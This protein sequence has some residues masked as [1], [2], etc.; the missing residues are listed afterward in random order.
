MMW[1]LGE[2]GLASRLHRISLPEGRHLGRP[3]R[4]LPPGRIERW[5]G[6]TVIAGAGHLAEWDAPAD[7]AAALRAVL[8]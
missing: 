6:G 8:A 2:R 3:G 7:V 5:G 4:A 1:P